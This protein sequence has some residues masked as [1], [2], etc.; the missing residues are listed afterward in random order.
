MHLKDLEEKILLKLIIT[1][2][3]VSLYSL[4]KEYKV[5]VRLLI[6][7]IQNLESCRYLD[8]NEDIIKISKLG[9]SY[10]FNKQINQKNETID[11]KVP[12]VFL[13]KKININEFY[14]PQNFKKISLYLRKEGGKM[15][16]ARRK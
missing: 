11:S 12:V 1:D 8:R 4:S 6:A 2:V 13:G 10:L 15:K 9:I 3:G 14:I 7:A 16:L 5:S